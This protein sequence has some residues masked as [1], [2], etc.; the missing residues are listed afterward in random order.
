MNELLSIEEIMEE[1]K[2]DEKERKVNLEDF[3]DELTE[4]DIEKILSNENFNYKLFTL[5]LILLLIKKDNPD[6][7][8]KFLKEILEQ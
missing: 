7:Y 8:E 3:S 6:N 4:E 1:L 5:A 2:E